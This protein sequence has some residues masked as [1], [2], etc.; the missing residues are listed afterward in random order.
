ML[1]LVGA[2]TLFG[3]FALSMLLRVAR[4]K[5]LMRGADVLCGV[6]LFALCLS[7]GWFALRLMPIV[8]LAYVT[9][10]IHWA[11]QWEIAHRR[12]LQRRSLGL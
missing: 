1:L 12:E 8:A 9:Y 5:R 3:L 2:C 6:Q 4:W 10:C 11:V 7:P